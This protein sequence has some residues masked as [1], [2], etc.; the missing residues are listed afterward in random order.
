MDLAIQFILQLTP[1]ANIH[2]MDDYADVVAYLVEYWEWDIDAYRT[3]L[4]PNIRTDNEYIVLGALVCLTMAEWLHLRYSRLTAEELRERINA[5]GHRPFSILAAIPRF[6]IIIIRNFE[7][8]VIADSPALACGLIVATMFPTLIFPLILSG[9]HKLNIWIADR[10]GLRCPPELNGAEAVTLAARDRSES[11]QVRVSLMYF[12]FTDIAP[13]PC[14]YSLSLT[15][16]RSC[17]IMMGVFALLR[18]RK[19]SIQ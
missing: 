4:N 6:G 17:P 7:I 1:F 8:V 18:S 12:L 15:T 5:M 3:Y 11:R 9:M 19:H 13:W 2:A 10:R 14:R 16:L